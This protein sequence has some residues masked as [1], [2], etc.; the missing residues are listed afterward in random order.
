MKE[1]HI[2]GGWIGINQVVLSFL[3]QRAKKESWKIYE[4]YPDDFPKSSARIILF[5]HTINDPLAKIGLKRIDNVN[6]LSLKWRSLAGEMDRVF[7]DLVL[8]LREK[9]PEVKI[10]GP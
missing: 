10:V 2:R 7:D 8:E 1:L 3:Q 9:C 6:W 5:T 4:A